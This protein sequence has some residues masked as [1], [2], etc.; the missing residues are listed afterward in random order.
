[1]RIAI[2]SPMRWATGLAA[3]AT[4][5]V[6]A[7]RPAPLRV[8]PAHAGKLA[9]AELAKIERE[10]DELSNRME[11]GVAALDDAETAAD[12]AAASDAI[13]KLMSD[14]AIIKQVDLERARLLRATLAR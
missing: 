8:A 6:L 13:V 11:T 10:L 4:V 12:R 3:I 9:R 5:A 1:M 7:V 2:S 14:I